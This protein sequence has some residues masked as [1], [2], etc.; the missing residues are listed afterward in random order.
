MIEAE[1]EISHAANSDIVFTVSRGKNFGALFDLANA[2]NRDL[3]LVD[4][5]R[6]EQSPEYAR[7]GNGEGSGGYF[8][9]FQLLCS[10]TIGEIVRGARNYRH[11]QAPIKRDGH[12]EIDVAFIDDLIAA[13]L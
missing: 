2:E 10:S 3:R 7:I 1:R 11:N 4:D 13:D 9:R 12:A 6:T 8:I 5:R